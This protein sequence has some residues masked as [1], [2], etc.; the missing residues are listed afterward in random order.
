MAGNIGAYETG[1][2]QFK[3]GLAANAQ[4]LEQA[5]F[6]DQQQT[7]QEELQYRYDALNANNNRFNAGLQNRTQLAGLHDVEQQQLQQL[8]SLA[9]SGRLTQ[10]EQAQK[11]L[12]E[13]RLE[14]AN[15]MATQNRDSREG[16]FYNGTLPQR[17]SAQE[18]A[19][20]RN[21]NNIS[22]REQMQNERLDQQQM[23][24]DKRNELEQAKQAARAGNDPNAYRAAASHAQDLI[25]IAQQNRQAIA[26]RQSQINYQIANLLPGRHGDMQRAT[27]TQQAQEVQ[28]AMEQAARDYQDAVNAANEVRQGALRSNSGSG[29][30]NN[31]GDPG[32]MGQP[33]GGDQS[34]ALP[35]IMGEQDY[36]QLPMGTRYVDPQGNVRMKQ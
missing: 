22:S 24:A 8:R 29:D 25:R 21:D 14:A 9:A 13:T 17:Y 10:Q 7:G 27:L 26:R 5:R 15:N 28:Q 11:D 34:G 12:L 4:A 6:Q 16:M 30:V 20:T 35:Q 1:Q 32:A 33:G 23:L 2:D 19:N 18:D 36:Q 3:N 31:M